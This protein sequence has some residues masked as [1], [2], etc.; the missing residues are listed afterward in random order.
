MIKSPKEFISK[1][2]CGFSEHVHHAYK[3]TPPELVE[4][5]QLSWAEGFLQIPEYKEILNELNTTKM[6]GGII[7]G[8]YCNTEIMDKISEIYI[9]IFNFKTIYASLEE[10]LFAT[11]ACN[12]TNNVSDALLWLCDQ[13]IESFKSLPEMN[14]VFFN[15]RIPRDINHPI[16]KYYDI[17]IKSK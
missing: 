9:R 5:R 11:I 13:T 10:V 6:Y 7:D 14:G 2:D 16:R 3:I 1:Y 8:S 12:L 15:K 17:L 4:P